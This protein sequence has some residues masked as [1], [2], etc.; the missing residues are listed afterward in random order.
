V[1]NETY[2]GNFGPAYLRSQKGNVVE[3]LLWTGIEDIVAVKSVKALILVGWQRGAHRT[4]S[5]VAYLFTVS[6][7]NT[8]YPSN[9]I[10][11]LALTETAF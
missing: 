7:I 2:H 5:L 9:H 10:R 4:K 11:F 8:I 1:I 3:S 6:N